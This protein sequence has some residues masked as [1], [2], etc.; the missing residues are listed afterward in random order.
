MLLS[1]LI[2]A[3]AIAL[4]STTPSA[5]AQ[6]SFGETMGRIYLTADQHETVSFLGKQ[7]PYQQFVFYLMVHLDFGDIGQPELNN[8]D[9]LAAWEAS[10]RVPEGVTITKR[11]PLPLA[12]NVAVGEDNWVMGVPYMVAAWQTPT[13]LVKYTAILLVDGLSDLV[14][15]IHESDPT[16]FDHPDARERGPGWLEWQPTGECEFSSRK[17]ASGCLRTFES[18]QDNRFVIN[19]KLEKECSNVARDSASWSAV[20]ARFAEN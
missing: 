14:I 4:P 16:T 20:K 5:M 7:A 11:E 15:T 12:V 18:W 9:G 1:C 8:V 17:P 3:V 19:C 6:T 13:V 2:V 10:L